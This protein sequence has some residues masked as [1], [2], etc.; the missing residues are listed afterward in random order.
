MLPLHG[1]ACSSLIFLPEL[2][3]NL[4]LQHLHECLVVWLLTCSVEDARPFRTYLASIPTVL[5]SEQL[6]GYEALCLTT[7][8]NRKILH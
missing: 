4:C 2:S 7:A 3:T 5:A 6:H 1:F 8:P